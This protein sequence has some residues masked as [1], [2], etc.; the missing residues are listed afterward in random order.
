MAAALAPSARAQAVPAAGG[1]GLVEA[2]DRTDLCVVGV[3]R[4]RRPL[5]AKGYTAQLVVEQAL[6]AGLASGSVLSIAWEELASARPPRFGDADRVLVCLS[7]LPG[8]TLWQRRFPDPEQRRAVF[9]V[10]NQGGR[11]QVTLQSGC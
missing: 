8:A 10:A 2:V 7:A 6:N 3:T 5:D 4:N 1:V 11:V 9:A